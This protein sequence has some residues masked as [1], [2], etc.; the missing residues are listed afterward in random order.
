MNDIGSTTDHPTPPP[1][2]TVSRK[3]VTPQA[4]ERILFRYG[5]NYLGL[6]YFC[7]RQRCRNALA[8]RG[9]PMSCVP[10]GA[11]LV[12]AA[13]RAFVRHMMDSQEQ[14]LTYEEALAECDESLIEAW[15]SWIA[16]LAAGSGL[17]IL[18]PGP[19]PRPAGSSA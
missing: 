17:K 1:T 13:A 5:A 2:A 8:C 10:N 3:G 12:P 18:P 6:Y 11:P 19:P 16:G 7:G 14:H 4:A 9:N 15:E